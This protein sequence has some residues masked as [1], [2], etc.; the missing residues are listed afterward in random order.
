MLRIVATA[1]VTLLVIQRREIKCQK[2]APEYL[3]GPLK[4][5]FAFPAA[6]TQKKESIRKAC[7]IRAVQKQLYTLATDFEVSLY[8]QEL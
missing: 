8:F 5:D 6:A 3:R 7:F 4:M 2:V 1:Y